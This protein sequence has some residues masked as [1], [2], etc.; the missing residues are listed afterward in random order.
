MRISEVHNVKEESFWFA[1]LKTNIPKLCFAEATDDGFKLCLG[2]YAKK[3]PK[4]PHFGLLMRLSACR[5]SAGMMG[6]KIDSL[7][8]LIE[9][10]VS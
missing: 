10:D 9:L 5:A 3:Y 2:I 6:C 7:V 4:K 8:F 1:G